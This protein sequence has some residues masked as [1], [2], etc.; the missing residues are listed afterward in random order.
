[1][2]YQ[3][4]PPSFAQWSSFDA[5]LSI[6]G[7]YSSGQGS[8]WASYRTTFEIILVSIDGILVY[9]EEKMASP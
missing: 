2:I 6:A 7:S 5:H 4:R 3:W 1:M 8:A 9:D